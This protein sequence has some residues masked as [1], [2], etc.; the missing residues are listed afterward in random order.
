MSLITLKMA[1]RMQQVFHQKASPEC[2]SDWCLEDDITCGKICTCG[3]ESQVRKKNCPLSSQNR[4]DGGNLF[5]AP[6][7]D[8]SLVDRF[9]KSKLHMVGTQL[10]KRQKPVSDKPPTVRKCKLNLK[11]GGYVSLH[12]RKLDNYHTPCCVM[13][14]FG[15]KCVLYFRKGVLKS[16]YASSE[17]L[18]LSSDWSISIENWRT[19]KKVSQICSK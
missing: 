12:E 2:H 3:A 1:S 17:L 16:G 14:M 5:P 8:Y 4:Y 7:S 10:G 18:A 6:S 13:Q 19:A 9:E 11:V 15:D